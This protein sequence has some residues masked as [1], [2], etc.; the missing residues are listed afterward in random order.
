MPIRT[1]SFP[2]LDNLLLIILTLL[3]GIWSENVSGA[4]APKSNPYA[5]LYISKK[6]GQFET[7]H[8]RRS[9]IAFF[10]TNSAPFVL[11]WAIRSLKNANLPSLPKKGKG[12]ENRHN[13]EEDIAWLTQNLNVEYL[14]GTGVL[15]V[16]LSA[17]SL[18]EQPLLVNAVVHAYLALEVDSQKQRYHKSLE[19]TK[20]VMKALQGPL[21]KA[22]EADKKNL[23][24]SIVAAQAS[25]KLCEEGLQTLPRLLELAEVPSE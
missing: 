13:N 15:R 17:G 3:G 14:D 7:A 4:P 12:G 18:R 6:T 21:G 10:K 20:S 22:N 5:L 23:E 8:Y 19:A 9:Q 2:L 16:S 11:F 24:Q 1:T 25:I